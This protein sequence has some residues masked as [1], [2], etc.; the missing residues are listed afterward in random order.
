MAMTLRAIQYFSAVTE[1]GS[2][3]GA[4]HNL[5]ISQATITESIQALEAHLSA[6]LF[7]R[8][9]RGMTLNTRGHEFLRHAE[10]IAA[11]VASAERA[12]SVRPDALV[13]D[14]MIGHHESAD[15]AIT[16]PA[17]W[18]ATA[19]HFPTY[20]RACTKIRVITSSISLI[21]GEIDT[22]LMIVSTLENAASFETT[23]LVRTP[24]SFG[25]PR[26]IA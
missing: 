18:S 20:G 21:N 10:R 14:L 16:C 13:G 26:A 9:A 25:F 2:I 22:A 1:A 19:V 17:C 4:A 3:S 6:L 8:H 7:R 23:V 15:P 5:N 24:G 12:L 11:A